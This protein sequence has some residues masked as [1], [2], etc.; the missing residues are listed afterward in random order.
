MNP[1]P[2]LRKEKLSQRKPAISKLSYLELRWFYARGNPADQYKFLLHLDDTSQQLFLFMQKLD[3]IEQ[4]LEHC[5]QPTSAKFYHAQIVLNTWVGFI[6]ANT[7]LDPIKPILLE[8]I[9]TAIPTIGI[10]AEKLLNYTASL[11][12]A[13]R[14]SLG[15]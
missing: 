3:Q 9:K 12:K 11:T 1:S 4:R 10:A 8:T 6:F 2:K 14:D 7:L 13:A 15:K 5:K